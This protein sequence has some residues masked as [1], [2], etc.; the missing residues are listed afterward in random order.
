MTSVAGRVCVFGG[1]DSPRNAFDRTAYIF[2]EGVWVCSQPFPSEPVLGH[3]AADADN[4][5]FV[6]G[7]RHGGTS[8]SLGE[9]AQ[10]A[11]LDVSDGSW[12]ERT[13]AEN[14]AWPDK[15]SFHAMCTGGGRVYVFGGCG[16]SGR[17]NDL[18]CYDLQ[19]CQWSCLHQGGPEA[20]MARGGA[21]LVAS[22]DGTRVVLLF[23]FSGKQH[24]DIAVF[25]TTA[26]AWQLLPAEAQQGDVPSPRSVFAA[27]ALD[28]HA[29]MF[30]G[31]REES[32]L[33]HEGAG[34]FVADVFA[35]DVASMEWARA[36]VDGPG[37]APRGWTEMAV[38]GPRQLLLFGGLDAS[39]TRLG[40][41]W[42]LSL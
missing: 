10:L 27:A 8:M 12:T 38:S 37:P 39:N 36:T 5:V 18:W 17:L 22:P 35:L 19:A 30:G 4:K 28:G 15:R 41:L 7:G 2:S 1:E 33:G 24:G 6:F 42:E 25:D 16:T 32:D 34:E 31:E 11:L 9:S 26:G 40:D 23:G 14:E 13:P 21:K 20:P 29:V 3:A